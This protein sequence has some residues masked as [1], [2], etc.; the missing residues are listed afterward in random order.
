MSKKL[1]LTGQKFGELTVIRTAPNIKNKT[2]WLCS[3]DCGGKRIVR[4]KD[5]RAG[6]VTSCGSCKQNNGLDTL[7][8]VDGTC[9]EM[10][11]ST[12]IRSNNRSGHTGVFQDSRSGK[13]RA[14]IM[15]R[16]KRK[17]LGR[18]PTLSDAVKAREKAKEQ[19]HDEFIATY[20]E[21]HEK[22]EKNT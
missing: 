19:L 15:L 5:L 8:Y 9:I 14:E 11:Q 17:S 16:G 1:N 22:D 21:N 4:T 7:H 10:L 12:T 2:A 3:C 13:W 20:W 18:F 6:K